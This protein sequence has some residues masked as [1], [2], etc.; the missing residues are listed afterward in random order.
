MVRSSNSCFKI[1]TCGSDSPVD[2]EDL[3]LN[4]SKSSMDK[5]GWSFRK[6]STRHRVLSNTVT[7]GTPSTATEA[8]PESTSIGFSVQSKTIPDKTSFSSVMNSTQPKATTTIENDHKTDSVN[9]VNPLESS[10]KNNFHISPDDASERNLQMQ[11]STA[12]VIQAAIRG[13]LAK[14]ELVK[15]KYVVK[16]QAAVR[17]HLVRGQAVGSLRC[18]QA[19]VKMQSLVRARYA[20]ASIQ[21]SDIEEKCD[22]KHDKGGLSRKPLG[23]E[24]LETNA[25]NYSSTQKWLSNGFARQ[26]LES[27]PKK[28]IHI[29]CDPSRP[30][31][32]WKWLERWMAVLSSDSAEPHTTE[33]QGK[34]ER[35]SIL[36]VATNDCEQVDSEADVSKIIMSVD[37]KKSSVS[38]DADKFDDAGF[39]RSQEISS[40]I[41]KRQIGTSFMSENRD[42]VIE[43]PK[44]SLKRVASEQP[45]YEG[46]NTVFESRKTCNPTFVAVKSK[47]EELSSSSAKSVKPVISTSRDVEVESK[48][49]NISSQSDRLTENS[50]TKKPSCL[51]GGSEGG[52]EISV[53]SF[54]DSPN[55]N[56][57]YGGKL[58]HE[59]ELV[60]ELT[61]G[62]NGTM[63]M[64]PIAK[65]LILK[66]SPESHITASG[67]YGTPS[68]EVSVKAK[69]NKVDKSGPTKKIKS[70]SAGNKPHLILNQDLDARSSTEQLLKESKNG[71]RRSSFGSARPDLGEEESRD[72]SSTI[73]SYMQATE[74]AKAKALM[75]TSPRSTPD[76]QDK[77][78]Y[79]KKR[80]SLPGANG[81]QISPRMQRSTSQ[82]QQGA[83]G[84]GTPPTQ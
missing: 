80:H 82:A 65:T 52:T 24:N 40:V 17:G 53:S 73:P 3:E 28:E 61:S 26:L 23:K 38:Y 79:I 74:S 70:H 62:R 5:R 42:S 76:L 46:N 36:N 34:I 2:N 43:Q 37:G 6:R 12:I 25:N 10:F 16:L 8:S 21:G 18:V 83:K 59:S 33:N 51:V 1:I 13:Y 69:R 15:L 58:E 81:K 68:S 19:I 27:T 75:N 54:L 9:P 44:R 41:E 22:R 14:K 55:K 78:I 20:C 72:S 84:N 4:E 77:D 35:N 56:Q 63:I 47:F 7:S 31:S 71:R 32:S 66:S 29:K 64:H 39:R 49:G 45:E 67:A 50:V 11:E 48:L 30:D 60:G 57:V